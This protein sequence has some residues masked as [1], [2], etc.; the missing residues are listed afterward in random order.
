V[1]DVWLPD[2]VLFE[3][4]GREWN[5]YEA[6]LYG[7]FKKDFLDSLPQWPQKRVGL[8]RQPLSADGKV[9]TFEHFISEGEHES[10]RTPDFR[11]CER[12]RWPRPTIESFQNRK[13][14]ATDKI[15]WWRNQRRNEWR[16]ILALPDFSYLVVVADRG[17]YVL[18]WTQY[19]VDREHQRE[20]YRKEYEDYWRKNG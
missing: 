18:P 3:D 20:K 12:I 17:D 19:A 8:K 14:A 15:V 5:T 13:P 16:Y 11:R 9:A 2:L 10:T 6:V 4:S 1:S 7:W